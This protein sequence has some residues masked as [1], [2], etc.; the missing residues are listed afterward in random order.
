M[1]TALKST[2][3]IKS[4]WKSG[5]AHAYGY[6]PFDGF[7]DFLSLP[8]A[9][10]EGKRSY[11]LQHHIKPGIFIA[12]AG[13]KWPDFLAC[14]DP[15]FGFFISQRVIDSL[16]SHG[17]P[18][19]RATHVPIGEIESDRLKDIPTPA[20]YAVEAHPGIAID[21][22]A[23]GF[24]TDSSGHPDLP[25]G[26]DVIVQLDPD[27]WSG[28]DL[29]RCSNWPRGGKELLSTERVKRI[30]ESEGWTNVEFVRQKIKGISLLPG[31]G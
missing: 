29:F 8:S 18:L 27:A 28:D 14:G 19:A 16:A 13:S 2:F 11:W 15:P 9:F 1:T 25:R 5:F 17:I 3:A 30:A 24:A 31:M 10:R 22:A 7:D 6:G 4:A 20:Y 12:G 21:Y 26:Q 23:S